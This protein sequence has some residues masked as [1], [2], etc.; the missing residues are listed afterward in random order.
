MDAKILPY[1]KGQLPHCDLPSVAAVVIKR[2]GSFHCYSAHPK[3][4]G[5]GRLLTST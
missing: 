1:H 2:R 3:S 4:Q 5:T